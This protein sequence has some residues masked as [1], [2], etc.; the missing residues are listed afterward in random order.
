MIKL[1]HTRYEKLEKRTRMPSRMTHAIIIKCNRERGCSIT[2][3]ND[4]ESKYN[5]TEI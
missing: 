2:K 4:A 5:S 3:K 1:R